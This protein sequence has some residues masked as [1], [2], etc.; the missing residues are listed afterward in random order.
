[1][2]A[3]IQSLGA[4]ALTGGQGL[5][6]VADETMVMRALSGERV[7]CEQLGERHRDGGLRGAA[8]ARVPA[9]PCARRASTTPRL[10]D[11]AERG[12]V[13]QARV[14]SCRLPATSVCA[15]LANI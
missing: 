5:M 9:L 8:A 6:T 13:N 15:P 10:S 12:G 2:P 11:P 4:L 7:A 14:G 3:V 1:M